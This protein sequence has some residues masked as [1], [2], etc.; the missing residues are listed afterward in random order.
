[1]KKNTPLVSIAMCTYNGERFLRE[2]LNSLIKQTYNNIELIIVDDG[3]SDKTIELIQ[4]YIENDNRIKLYQNENNLGFVKNFEQAISLCS[5]DYIAL[6]DQDDIWYLNKIEVFL[7]EIKNNILIYSDADLI[8]KESILTGKQLIRPK[9]NLVS[10][11]CYKSLLFYNCVSGNTMMFKKEL[12]T[13]ILPIQDGFSF[14]DVWIAFIA[15][16]LGT[17][18]YTDKAMIK[19]RRY[20][21]QITATLEKNYK[22]FFDRY[23]K[24][25]YKQ[26]KKMQIRLHDFK[27][28][29]KLDFLNSDEKSIIEL[30]I[31]HN[32]NFNKGFLNLKLYALLNKNKHEFFFIKNKAKRNKDVLKE[33]MKV[34]MH[35]ML[36]FTF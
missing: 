13:K 16:T 6:A 2:Q 19:Y 23:R 3:S 22:S 35:K 12:V 32:K 4:E 25:R 9:K 29:S 21:E 10:G 5:G 26:V 14:H 30:L 1:L 34:N 28:L 7:T 24:K 20:D 8:D 15:S 27:C 31:E 17:I 36:F 18:C 11:R 33:S